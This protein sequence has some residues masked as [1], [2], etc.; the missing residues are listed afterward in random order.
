MVAAVALLAATVG[1]GGA[2]VAVGGSDSTAQADPTHTSVSLPGAVATSDE[3]AVQPQPTRRTTALLPRSPSR[4]PSRN[5]S[6]QPRPA[7]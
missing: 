7:C 5:P 2:L 3:P 4:S 1:F 6:P